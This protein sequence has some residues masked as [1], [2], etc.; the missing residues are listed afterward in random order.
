MLSDR[1]VDIHRFHPRRYLT[2]DAV[3]RAIKQRLMDDRH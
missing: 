1:T 3:K 2:A